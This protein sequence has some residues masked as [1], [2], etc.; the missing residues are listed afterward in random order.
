LRKNLTDKSLKALKPAPSGKRLTI[1]DTLSPLS[2]RVTGTGHV[3]FCV[4][5]RLPGNKQPTVFTIGSYPQVTLERARELAREA[6][7]A[8]SRGTDPNEAKRAAEREA[9]R[10]RE[11]TFRQ[12]AEDFRDLHC[13]KLRSKKGLKLWINIVDHE[14]IPAWGERSAAGIERADVAELISEVVDRDAPAQAHN[15]FA[16]IRR[17][18]NWGIGR[19][20]YGLEHSPCDRLRPKDLIGERAIRTRVLTDPELRLLWRLAPELGYPFGPLTRLIL[21]CGSRRA[22]PGNAKWSNFNEQAA[23]LTVPAKG[24]RVHVIPLPPLALQIVQQLPRF[25]GPYMFSANGGK[26]PVEDF[27]GA[28]ERLNA[29]M[30]KTELRP[31][32][33]VPVDWAHHD[34]RRTARTHWSALPVADT[35]REL[36]LGH[37]QKGLHKVYDQ[38]AY[39][40]E[41]RECLTLW[42]ARLLSLCEPPPAEPAVDAGNVVPLR[43][44]R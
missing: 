21:L 33:E 6:A 29:I 36:C 26:K 32:E 13:A 30:A 7:L 31:G 24:D 27:N 40:D 2:V 28:K 1:G 5:R 4:I 23:T 16:V 34:L 14:L 20:K 9:K 39:L 38:Y 3:S 41:K 42:E 15:I 18:Y 25:A 22:E 10:Q 19:E 11:V 17:L 12:V 8:M 37:T 35:V 43:K 44:A